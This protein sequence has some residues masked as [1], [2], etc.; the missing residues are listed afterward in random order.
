MV[1]ARLGV[2]RVAVVDPL[3]V[4]EP[5]RVLGATRVEARAAPGVVL[6]L[7]DLGCLLVGE[8]GGG[9]ALVVVEHADPGEVRT[10]DRGDAE[11]SNPVERL[12]DG[13]ISDEEL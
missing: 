6:R 2:L 11:L 12:S 3:K 13:H 4:V 10:G 5:D 9:G 7:V 1:Q 8:Q